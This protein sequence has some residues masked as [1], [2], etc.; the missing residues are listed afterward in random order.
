M[1]K[2]EEEVTIAPHCCTCELQ[3][4]QA[5]AKNN[6]LTSTFVIDPWVSPT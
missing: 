4:I 1:Q 5:P 3:N 2:K 6:I